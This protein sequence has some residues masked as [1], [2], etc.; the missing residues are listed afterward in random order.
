M[1]ESQRLVIASRVLT[2]LACVVLV[3]AFALATL[4]PVMMPLGQALLSL[5]HDVLAK[6]HAAV[7]SHLSAGVWSTIVA[8]CLER[9]S[10]LLPTMLGIVLAGL[11]MSARPRRSTPQKRRRSN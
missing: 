10:W 3:C 5:D 1:A 4:L 8:P 2:V 9:P 6:A 7:T 11:A